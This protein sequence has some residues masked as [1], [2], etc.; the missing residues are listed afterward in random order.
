MWLYNQ[1]VRVKDD[2]RSMDD[3]RLARLD[4][5]FKNWRIG[6]E[7][8][9][10]EAAWCAKFDELTLFVNKLVVRMYAL[11]YE[12]VNRH[13]LQ[14]T[15]CLLFCKGQR[16]QYRLSRYPSNGIIRNLAHE[17]TKP[18]KGSIKACEARCFLPE[19]E[20]RIE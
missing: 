15:T 17:S 1:R 7:R 16:R 12:C 4:A 11:L 5:L 10:V 13:L 8:I 18:H 20:K 6:G 14:I 19:L 3:S 2:S 9:R